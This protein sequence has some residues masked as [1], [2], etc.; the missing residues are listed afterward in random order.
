MFLSR[1]FYLLFAGLVGPFFLTGQS[2]L[3]QQNLGGSGAEVAN[4]VRLLPNRTVIVAGATRSNDGMLAG[5]RQGLDFDAWLVKL[6]MNG[7]VL[8]QRSLGGTLNDEARDVRIT[9]D[10][11]FM[12]AGY[13]ESVELTGRSK[14]QGRDVWLA[15]TDGLG[16][17]LWSKTY[18]GAGNDVAHV[19][20]PLPDGGYLL[21]GE[22]GSAGKKEAP[23]S[24]VDLNHGGLDGWVLR[25]E[26]DG[27]IRWQ[28]CLGGE[29]NDVLNAAMRLQSGGYLLAGTSDSKDGDL[30]LNRG[31]TDG[32]LAMLDEGGNLVWSKSYGGTSYEELHAAGQLP[33]GK[34]VVAGTTFSNDGDVKGAKG[35]GDVWLLCLDGN[36]HLLWNR[37]YGGTGDE[38]ANGLEV[39]KNGQIILA[40]TSRSRDGERVTA[41]GVFD[42][43]L[44][45]LDAQGYLLWQKSCGGFQN[46]AFLAAT[47]LPGG[48]YLAVGYT[49]SSDGDLQG[50]ET[51]GS[52]DL[53]CAAL[54]PP[55]PA[56]KKPEPLTLISGY[57]LDKTTR[58]KLK[59]EVYL[60][61]TRS[62]RRLNLIH[63]NEQTGIFQM[64]L[65]TG[66]NAAKSGLTF[67]A[68]AEG[69]MLFALGLQVSPDEVG[70][71]II[72]DIELE[73][74]STGAAVN[75]YHVYFDIASA[76][77]R[78][79]G[80]LELESLANFMLANPTVRIKVN[81]HT[82]NT[83]ETRRMQ[84]LSQQRAQAVKT[85]LMGK[86]IYEGR[87][88]IEGLGAKQPIAPNDTEDGRAR[89]RR[90]EIV[91]TSL[92]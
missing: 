80:T 77:L 52:N 23:G 4:A 92:E 66:L 43:W 88:A 38:G 75:L 63:T 83:G 53:W 10:G 69:Y 14:P 62:K 84:V 29:G 51:Y 27:R 79:E 74:V 44:L 64:T 8:W 39:R 90:V 68:V 72:R 42:G 7:A 20:L 6:N 78:P 48:D 34:L 28:K 86:G 35:A 17:L 61:D 57:V 70:T 49:A 54:Q 11:G 37:C 32:W 16:A 47:E 82:D 65:P 2:I 22:T 24:D 85:Y 30:N 91:I 58:K 81:G 25:L 40:A 9:P 33:D 56:N 36:G 59:A 15:K 31:K 13:T 5:S 55:Q 19:L 67:N 87:L 50:M 73:R 26:A 1:I 71:E 21:V 45:M 12:I 76:N 41:R 89:N 18:G 60:T 46:E 3:W